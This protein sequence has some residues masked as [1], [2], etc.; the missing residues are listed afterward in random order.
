MAKTLMIQGT[1][2]NVEKTTLTAGLCR[3]LAQ[4]GHRVAP[5][6]PQNLASVAYITKSGDRIRIGQAVQAEAAGIEPDGRMNP[7]LVKPRAG[8][9]RYVSEEGRCRGSKSMERWSS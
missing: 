5:F 7:F 2:S 6:K 4:D 3:I 1:A 9:L 8:G